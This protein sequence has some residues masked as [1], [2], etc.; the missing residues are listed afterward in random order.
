MK[1]YEINLI[2][3][4]ALKLENVDTLT[5]LRLMELAQ[6]QRA[7]GSLINQKIDEYRTQLQVDNNEVNLHLGVHKTAT[8]FLQEH[9]IQ[10]DN[11]DFQYTGL[12]KFRSAKRNLGYFGYLHSLDWGKKTLISDE[13]LIGGNGTLLSGR[14]YPSFHKTVDECLSGFKNRSLVTVYIT[15]RPMTSFVPSQY[16]EHLR[17]SPYISYD[18]FTSRVDVKNL[19]WYEVLS[20]GIRAHSDIRF[21]I[22][23]FRNFSDY[24]TQLLKRLSFELFDEFDP[25]ITPSRES[26]GYEEL[27]KLSEGKFSTRFEGK[28]NPHSPSD[29]E[30]SLERYVDD[31]RKFESLNNVTV[32]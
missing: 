26:F 14:L 1:Y 30:A 9:L 10:L 8:T 21:E 4:A 29:H 13:N 23:D 24:K 5:A 11:P 18:E 27:V 28:F 15:I 31:L 17:W 19:S 3:D 25:S 20:E 6:T 16:C 7:Q 32:N 2:R 22:Y 12:K